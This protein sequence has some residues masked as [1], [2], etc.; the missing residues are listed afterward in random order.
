MRRYKIFKNNNINR[1]CYFV[2]M[3][4]NKLLS[5]GID[6]EEFDGKWKIRYL[7][8]YYNHTLEDEEHFPVVAHVDIENEIINS[9]LSAVERGL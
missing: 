8:Q 9:I 7:A 3:A 1:R 4:K 6:I 5:T 2:R